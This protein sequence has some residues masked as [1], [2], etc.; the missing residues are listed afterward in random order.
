MKKNKSSISKSGSYEKVG[1][2]WDSHDLTDFID[3][4]KKTNFDVDITREK[5]YCSLDKK[6]SSDLQI[7]ANKQG[8]SPDVL[9]NK[10]LQEK[11][12]T[13]KSFHKPHNP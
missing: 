1:E 11:L 4:T 3:Q 5:I 12:K 8:I 6:I 2:F 13:I 9:V 7:L 10:I